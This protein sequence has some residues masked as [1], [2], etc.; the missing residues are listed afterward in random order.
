MGKIHVNRNRQ[1]LGEFSPQEVADGLRSGRFLPTDLAW[2][3]GMETWQPLATFTDLPAPAEP[4]S[5]DPSVAPGSEIFDPA[6]S[7]PPT[8]PWEE[9][10]PFFSR[11]FDT[12]LKVLLSPAEA[13]SNVPDT[14]NVGR[15][16][17]YLILIGWPCTVVSLAYEFI[18]KA[19]APTASA[20][21]AATA[22]VPVVTMTPG[23]MI[24]LAVFSPLFLVIGAFFSAGLFHLFLMVLGGANRSFWVTFRVVT[25]VNAST[26]VFNLFPFCG[27]FIQVVW[28]IVSLTIGLR[29]AQKT[30]TAVALVSALLPILVCCGLGIALVTVGV[31]ALSTLQ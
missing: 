25:Y 31:G 29:E 27:G 28:G 17:L 5:T 15:P 14:G 30:T 24:L 4:E 18:F 11:L 19:I 2:R 7:A 20:Q 16:L 8:P 22:D 21:A 3:E 1:N 10:K 12:I 13:F 23:M 9:E 26:V 6:G